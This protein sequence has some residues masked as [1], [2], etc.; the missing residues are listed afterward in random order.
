MPDGR[1]P[2]R[3]RKKEAAAARREAM[4]EMMERQRK[5]RMYTLAGVTAFLILG[6]LALAALALRGTDDPAASPSPAA[7][8]GPTPAPSPRPIACDGSLPDAAGAEKQTWEDP[9]ADQKLDRSKTYV[10]R[11]ETSCGRIDVELAVSRAPKTVNSVVFLTRNGFYDGLEFHRVVNGFVIQGGDPEGTGGGGPGY[12]IVEA[13]PRGL[14]Y[15]RG[16]VAMAKAGP[17]PAGTSGSQFFIASADTGLPAEYALVGEVV[18][19]MDVVERIAAL[20]PEG[21]DAQPPQRVFIE[22]ASIVVGD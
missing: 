9:P 10:W 18:E 19:G 14:S 12:Q 5:R 11:L 21:V 17:D 2:K 8:G 16:I 4:R 13:P 6:G 1:S 3:A 7:T 22:K 20:Q 15:D